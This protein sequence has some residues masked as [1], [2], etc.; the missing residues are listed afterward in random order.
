MV[1]MNM[2]QKTVTLDFCIHLSTG[3]SAGFFNKVNNKAVRTMPSVDFFFFP[4]AVSS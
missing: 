2:L 4:S 1:V 3:L